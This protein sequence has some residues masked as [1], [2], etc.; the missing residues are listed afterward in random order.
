MAGRR[1]NGEGSVYQR[2]S[3]GRWV[4]AVTVRYTATGTM[5]RKT[6]TAKTKAEVLTKMRAVRRNLD[7]GLPTPDDRLTVGQVLDRWMSDVLRHQVAPIAFENYK[8]VAD[9]HIRP[10]LGKRQVTKLAPADVDA[11]M[12]AKLDAGYS[13]STVRRIRAILVQALNQAE[14]WGLV[15]RNVAAVTRGPRAK[16]TEGRTLTPLQ[17]RQLLTSLS[18]HRLETLY[19]TMLGLGLR[20]GEALGLAWADVALD[21]GVL[22]IRYALKREG[23]T[24]VLGEVKTAKS[25]RSLNIPRPVVE[26]LK[27]HRARQAQERLAVGEAW[28]D[29]GLVFTTQV[30]TPL[31]P[32]N[33][34][35]DFVGVCERSGLGRW[36]PHELRHSAASI[37]LA[38]GVPIEVVSDILGH[39][40]IRMTADVY[41]HILEPQR[42][43]A[44]DAMAE[45]LWSNPGDGA[46]KS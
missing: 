28:T 43:A 12:S 46:R 17:A 9:L 35:R 16:R 32:R 20:R 34:Y 7:D 19:V 15:V 10:T 21:R 14:R 37:M 38:Q 22:L 5:R 44:A 11:L 4:G 40:S 30:G 33:I 45:A 23:G 36:H 39:S 8:S 3:D 42:L 6:V 27:A 26:S 25:R 24:L 13:V 41:G 1:M 29:S 2:T 31:D 18:G